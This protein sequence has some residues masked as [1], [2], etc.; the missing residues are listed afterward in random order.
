[1]LPAFRS[2]SGPEER[3]VQLV[4][5]R[6]GRTHPQYRSQIIVA[7]AV[8]RRRGTWVTVAA[9]PGLQGFPT[10]KFTSYFCGP[11]LHG[12]LHNVPLRGFNF[13]AL[14][15]HNLTDVRVECSARGAA[16]RST[17]FDSAIMTISVRDSEARA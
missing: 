15:I 7:G 14:A 1:M 9:P 8:A 5:A 13:A 12:A 16:Y 11:A 3:S 2:D 10:H 17:S 4:P 6:I